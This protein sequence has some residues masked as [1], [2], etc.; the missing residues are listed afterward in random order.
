MPTASQEGDPAL[1]E[2]RKK[3]QVDEIKIFHLRFIER[4]TA[5]NSISLTRNRENRIEMRL[6][7]VE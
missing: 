3:P 1:Q 6:K 5:V 7:E 2:T 4:M